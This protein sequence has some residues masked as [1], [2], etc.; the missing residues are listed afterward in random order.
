[1]SA[2]HVPRIDVSGGATVL[3][4]RRLAP[5]ILAA[6]EERFPTAPVEHAVYPGLF[7]CPSAVL[8][9]PMSGELVGMTDVMQPVAG[10]AGCA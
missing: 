10:A 3:A 4:D 7:A 2:F 1:E 5:E 6:L 9:E 8:R